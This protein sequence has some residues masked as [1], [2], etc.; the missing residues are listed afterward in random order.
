MGVHM[1]KYVIVESTRAVNLE[2]DGGH[3]VCLY[4]ILRPGNVVILKLDVA[5]RDARGKLRWHQV[6]ISDPVAVKTLG[7]IC[8]ELTKVVLHET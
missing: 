5:K 1:K 2:A 4:H 8:A 3:R 6:E 7:E